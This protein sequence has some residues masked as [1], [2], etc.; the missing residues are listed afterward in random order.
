MV[1]LLESADDSSDGDG[2][3]VP[4]EDEVAVARAG[5]VAHGGGG[6]GL[7]EQPVCGEAGPGRQHH[8]QH[9]QRPDRHRWGLHEVSVA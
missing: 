2:L 5:E 9:Q 6:R 8:K 1:A 3:V 7:G 4:S